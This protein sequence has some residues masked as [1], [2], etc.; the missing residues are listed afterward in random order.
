MINSMLFEGLSFLL[1]V[2]L[3]DEL[4]IEESILSNS[5]EIVDALPADITLAPVDSVSFSY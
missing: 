4:E 3:V 5:G 1:A 2:G